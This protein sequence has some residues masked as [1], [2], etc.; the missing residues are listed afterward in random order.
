MLVI[1]SSF[2]LKVK[3]VVSLY[4]LPCTCSFKEVFIHVHMKEI[5]EIEILKPNWRLIALG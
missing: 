2:K 1:V 4:N 3:Y 5:L